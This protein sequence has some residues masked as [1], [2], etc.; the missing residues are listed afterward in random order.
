MSNLKVLM[1]PHLESSRGAESGV[2]TIIR[3]YF[4]YLP[5]YGI[6]LVDLKSESYDLRAAHAGMTGKHCEVAHLHGM[7]W[8][9]DYQASTAE[10]RANAAIVE[11]LRGAVEVT[12][13]SNWVA[14]VL[15]RDMRFSPHVIAHGVDWDEWQHDYENE[16]YVIG[17]AKNRAYFDVCDPSFLTDL[18]NHYQNL[19]IVSTF[20]PRVMPQNNN[21]IVTGVLPY[22]KF[23]KVVQKAAVLISPL[24]ETWGILTVEAMAAGVPVLGF[25]HGGNTDIIEHGVNGYLAQVNNIQDLIQGLEYCLEHRA[26]LS[27]NARITSRKWTWQAACEQVADV[28]KLAYQNM[29]YPPKTI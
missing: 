25:N 1:I 13:P 17:Y 15:Q 24:K 29:I 27:Q 9:G 12:V 22:E 21:I 8:T 10:K 20:A 14:E 19:P 28:Y 5:D 4:Q 26:I 6:D 23:K 2:N 18:A 7:Y 11:A 3:K 16:G